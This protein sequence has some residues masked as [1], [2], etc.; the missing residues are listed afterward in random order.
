M[1]R[2]TRNIFDRSEATHNLKL[3]R[4]TAPLI[5]SQAQLTVLHRAG[6]HKP[7]RAGNGG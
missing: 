4:K 2:S 7:V 3:L 6:H 5:R 1:S